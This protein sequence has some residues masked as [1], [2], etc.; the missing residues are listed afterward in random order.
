MPKRLTWEAKPSF[1]T[2]ATCP[3][4][5]PI[6][7]FNWAASARASGPSCTC[8]ARKTSEVRSGCRP[9]T[10]RPPGRQRPRML[11]PPCGLVVLGSPWVP[12]PNAGQPPVGLSERALQFSSEALDLLLQALIVSQRPFQL[13]PEQT[14]LPLRLFQPPLSGPS[15]ETT[16]PRLQQPKIALLSSQNLERASQCRFIRPESRKRIRSL[17]WLGNVGGIAINNMMRGSL[18]E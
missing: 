14:I 10:R 3:S 5:S 15:L 7:L 18:S 17:C 6:G 9:C 8:A 11:R 2:S 1:S 4:Y 12:R 13:L 16:H